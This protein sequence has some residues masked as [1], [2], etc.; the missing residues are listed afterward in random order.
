MADRCGT[1]ELRGIKREGQQVVQL[2]LDTVYVP[3][4]A[5]IFGRSHSQAIRFNEIMELGR[6]III[7]GGPGSGKTTV[8]L[9]IARTLTNAIASDNPSL[10]KKKIGLNNAMPLPIFIPLDAYASY[11]RRLSSASIGKN[12]REST[13][14]SFISRYLIEKQTSFGLPDDFFEKLINED[15]DAIT[16]LDKFV[17]TQQKSKR[18]RIRNAIE[19]L[20]DSKD[21]IN[22]L[23]KL[24]PLLTDIEQHLSETKQRF[25]LVDRSQ[26]RRYSVEDF[27]SD[28]DRIVNSFNKS[29]RRELL[30]GI[31][32]K[33]KH[34]DVIQSL[35]VIN[36]L[37]NEAEQ[38]YRSIIELLPKQGVILLLDGLDEVPNEAERVRVRQAIEELV[39]GRDHLFVIVTCRSAAYKD[40]TALGKG[41]IEVRVKPLEQE[42]V[43]ALIQQAYKAIYRNNLTLSQIKAD[44]LLQGIRILEEERQK[45]L[46]GYVSRLIT[47]PLMI[48]M[49]IVVHFSERRLPEQRA[50]LYMKATD[51]MLL[52]EYA[53]DE[54]VA[55]RI[56]RLVGGSREAHRDLLQY[57]AFQMH[58]R[59]ETQGRE[60]DEEELR[61]LLELEP[62]FR[63]LVDDFIFLTRLRGTLME[64]RLGMYRF[65]H[66]A[67][68]EYLTAR[69]LAEI[70]R[71]EKGIEGMAAFFEEGPITDSWWREVALLIA[72]YLSVTSP[73]T[74]QGFIKRLAGVDY[75]A[76][77]RD[78][79]LSDKVAV[80]AATIAAMACIEWQSTSDDLRQSLVQRLYVLFQMPNLAAKLR[81]DASTALGL[82]GDPR[83]SVIMNENMEFCWISRGS[84]IMGSE[85]AD[86]I[87]LEKPPQEL[88]I[89]Y[90]YAL[91][92]YP[93]TNSQYQEFVQN[94]G[95][96]IDRYWIRAEEAGYWERGW[97]KGQNRSIP[98]K[99]SYDYGTPFNVSN[100]PVVGISLYE[101]LAYTCWLT[102]KWEKEGVLQDNYYVSLPNEAEWE[103]GAKGGLMITSSPIIF[104]ID[105]LHN[106]INQ[107]LDLVTNEEPNRRFPWGT[108][109][110]L[111]DRANFKEEEIG[112][113]S[114]V[115]CFPNGRS[116]YGILD[117]SG[118]IY[119]WTRSTYKRYPFSEQ[120]YIDVMRTSRKEMV[121]RGN[122]YE[123][124]FGLA[125]CTNRFVDTPK[126][127]SKD[128]GFRI[129][130]IERS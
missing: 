3:L 60:I 44:E 15:R 76:H 99:N 111:M 70:V 37:M 105:N 27:N 2:D 47:S 10:S 71:G 98:R 79:A 118:N 68:Q 48:R 121:F 126:R 16:L 65:I 75:N 50:E 41:F 34:P 7:T 117:M 22:N 83:K 120:S 45:R 129:A 116:P 55:D 93:I 94:G 19:A 39:T 73:G 13:L 12:P 119:E 28:L 57:I 11:L 36:K 78:H 77:K 61:T 21:V 87:S 17:V 18:D 64:E 86:A 125:R 20:V 88:N 33:V 85:D 112:T 106:V 81:V 46:F 54:E 24:S 9:Y 30:I 84:F 31:Q 91:G 59:G 32:E 113:T 42:H 107:E 52:P 14:A 53:P 25:V 6:R 1:L 8:M 95:Y 35:T 123:S 101:A 26:I 58:K 124:T 90:N 49:I 4:E 102:E 115:G 67:F 108:N 40:R 89:N 80:Q 69:Y 38:I 109:Q 56:G 82:I 29:E 128:L 66:L 43:E 23:D 103:K 122:S 100:H 104:T 110:D 74:A 97:V 51:A 127:I 92:R 96:D 63:Q 114:A 130:I 5:E 72:G 62:I